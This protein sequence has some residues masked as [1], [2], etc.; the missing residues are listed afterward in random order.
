MFAYK[1]TTGSAPLYLNSLLQ[2][3]V[4]C[5]DLAFCK[6]MLHCNVIQKMHINVSQTFTLTVPCWWNACPTRS[7]QLCPWPSSRNDKRHISSINTDPLTQAL[8]ILFQFDLLVVFLLLFFLNPIF[9][10]RLANRDL[11]LHLHFI[12]FGWVWLL[13]LSSFAFWFWA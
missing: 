3:C 12:F 11:P 5:K 10:L 2:T 8:C 7:E 6:W 4:R 13:L 9:V 1:T